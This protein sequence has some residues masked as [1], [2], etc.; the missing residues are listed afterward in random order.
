MET[1][2]FLTR[3]REPIVAA[4]ASAIVR[5]H[6]RHYESAGPEELERRLEELFD[7]VLEAVTTHDL[8]SMIRHAEVVAEERF[9]GGYDLSEVQTAFN[10]L[11]ES[12]WSHALAELEPSQLAETLGLVST[13]LG[14][15]KDALARRY[16]SLAAGTHAPSLDLRTLFAGSGGA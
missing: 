11:E 1:A 2:A 12:V 10:A 4:A 16:V 13:V 14:A 5:A 6:I 15:G 9:N 8:G 3:D 7:H